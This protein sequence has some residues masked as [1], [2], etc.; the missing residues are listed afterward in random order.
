MW[1]RRKSPRSRSIERAGQ[2]LA[3]RD[4]TLQPARKTTVYVLPHSHTDI[5]YTAL[6]TEI[7]DKQVNNLL[8]GIEAAR[9]TASYPP[10]ARFVWNVE[11][12]WAADLY[13][14][15]LGEAQRTLFRDAL[16]RGQITPTPAPRRRGRSA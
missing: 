10:G 1:R 9:R 13:L 5:G 2:T 14:N 3:S 16:Q 15:R 6:Q 4:I 7:E 8:L 11:V 12:L